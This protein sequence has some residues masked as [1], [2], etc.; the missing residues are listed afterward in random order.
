MLCQKAGMTFSSHGDTVK[1]QRAQSVQSVLSTK[2]SKRS[3]RLPL[4]ADHPATQRLSLLSAYSPAP[5]RHDYSGSRPSQGTRSRASTGSH[6][7]RKYQNGLVRSH[8]LRRSSAASIDILFKRR[9][10]TENDDGNA[11]VVNEDSDFCTPL[12]WSNN[13]PSGIE[14]RRWLQS[15]TSGML[16]TSWMLRDPCDAFFGHLRNN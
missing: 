15:E 14:N 2:R 3:T 13:D 1:S 16:S 6:L 7:L 8:Y 9:N 5:D 11:S 4:T 10:G 12:D